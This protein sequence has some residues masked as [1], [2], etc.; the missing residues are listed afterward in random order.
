MLDRHKRARCQCS[1]SS[2]RRRRYCQNLGKS[3]QYRARPLRSR[4]RALHRVAYKGI[5]GCIHAPTYWRKPGR[6][7]LSNLYITNPNPSLPPTLYSSIKIPG[8][9]E[10][11][12]Y[13]YYNY[14]YSH[15]LQMRLIALNCAIVITMLQRANYAS[16]AGAY[17]YAGA[18]ANRAPWPGVVPIRRADFPTTPS[19][20]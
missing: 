8:H 14:L 9:E 17:L 2:S 1:S 6:Y 13:P 5:Q 18:Y 16:K 3:Q 7:A 10:K 11:L 20:C 4:R 19:I 12:Q 15:F